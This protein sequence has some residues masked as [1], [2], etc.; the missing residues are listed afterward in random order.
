MCASVKP[1]RNTFL[2]FF[3][4]ILPQFSPCK[5]V[6]GAFDA[7]FHHR[8]GHLIGIVDIAVIVIIIRVAAARADKFCKT[9]VAFL[10]RE[11]TAF[12]K[13]FADV[14]VDLSLEHVAHNKIFVACKLMARVNIP[15]RHDGKIFVPRP[16]CRN[17]LGKTDRKS[18]V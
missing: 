1:K 17:A 15:V 11:Q 4:L 14:P 13:F 6:H 12:G 9:P 8:A 18:V 7:L 3:N 5:N 10:A 2:S 16:A